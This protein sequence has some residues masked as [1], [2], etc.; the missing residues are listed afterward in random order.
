MKQLI[1]SFKSGETLIE[2]VP[3]PM[4]IPGHVLVKTTRSLV[5]LG[6][7]K[8]LVKFG[9][10]GYIE[11][12]RQ[13]PEKV[14]MVMDKIKTDGL[15][16]TVESVFNKLNH[17]IP[18][19]YCNVGRIEEIGKE[20]NEFQVGDRVISNGPHAEYVSVP[21]NLC[22]KIPDEV[23]DDQASFTV[24]SSIGLQG[25]RLV[26]P[27][28]GETIVVIGLGLIGLITAELL[29]SN[30]CNVIGYDFDD[31]KVQIAKNKGIDAFVTSEG[32]DPVKYIMEK[33]G[34]KGADGVLITA[35]TSKNTVIS[36]AA[37]MSRKR[38]RIVLV[39]VIGL[40][41]NRNE[42]YEK[43]LSFQLSCSYGPGRYDETY[44]Q[45]G[46]DYPFG[47]VRWTEKRN[48]EAILNALKNKQL[49]VDELITEKLKFEDFR[50]VY[51]NIDASKSIATLFEYSQQPEKSSKIEVNNINYRSGNG[52][53]GIIGAGNYTGATMLPALDSLKANIKYISSLE[54]LNATILAKKYKI[55]YAT[56]NYKEI[57]NDNEID[58][59]II[60]TRHDSH[61]SLVT[62]ALEKGKHVFVEKPLAINNRQLS[63][64][65]KVKNLKHEVKVHVGFNR[66]FAPLAI[67]AKSLLGNN[68]MNI[69]ATMNA[70]CIPSNVWVHD[71]EVG[72]GRIIGEA[73]HFIDLC[74][75]F[76]G[77]KVAEVC[78]NALG[79]N[80]KENSDNAS[81]LLKFKNGS[82]AVVN[83]FSNGAKS[84]SKERVEIFSQE[85]VLI[86]DNWR[87][88]KGYGINGFSRQKS[89]LDKGHKNQFD[90]FINNIKNGAPEL[91]SFEN[92]VNTTV[93][94]FA[95]IESLK[96]NKWVKC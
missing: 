95:A 24:I 96:Q 45:K 48:F 91:I 83:Y 26:N 19:G 12:A 62:E 70:G 76:T 18:L 54:G 50:K 27:T 61:A 82:T 77:S 93:A 94:S 23:S 14:K 30:G 47:F 69:I 51:E 65:I 59:V 32:N 37:N 28:F 15:K 43:E 6:T 89:K 84:Y 52:I 72:G 64:L 67:K 4:V 39:G 10:A 71:L 73:C 78:M 81:I 40:D 38:G 57:L 35:S 66:R 90:M 55:H 41:I 92:I 88:L 2:E 53:I 34:H 56:S 16:P 68:Q 11:K 44:E 58:T 29:K 13:Q 75:Y 36:D 79:K 74:S 21:K 22:A 46:I 85:K 20:V 7:E 42:F 3:K 86:I 1:Q 31:Y 17:P 60:T 8:M 87:S 49:K 80:P 25:I 9:K 63:E 33:T 5:S